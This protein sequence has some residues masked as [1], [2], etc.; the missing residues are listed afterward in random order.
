MKKVIR[1]VWVNW[2]K[3][4]INLINFIFFLLNFLQTKNVFVDHH[5]V[6]LY[7]GNMY[8]ST[9]KKSSILKHSW[10]EFCNL[11]VSHLKNELGIVIFY[12]IWETQTNK[13][14]YTPYCAKKSSAS[15]TH[16]IARR[17]FKVNP[18]RWYTLKWGIQ[19]VLICIGGWY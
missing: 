6:T 12:S 8:V 4:S 2:K 1:K 7:V 13:R 15:F 9:H 3:K 18:F 14:I 10:C 5:I 17:Y 11:F 19:G 16:K